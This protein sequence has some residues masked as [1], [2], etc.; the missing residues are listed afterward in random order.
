MD[1]EEYAS[2]SEQSDEDYCPN[3]ENNSDA[4][5]EDGSDAVVDSSDDEET[6]LC[7]NS[8]RCT[9]KTKNGIKKRSNK[10]PTEDTE[11]STENIEADNPAD[12]K[13]KA[14]ALWADFLT[15][16]DTVYSR[17]KTTP[18][19]TPT[20]S[21]RTKIPDKPASIKKQ[22]VTETVEF[23]GEKI[24]VI[25]EIAV[26]STST[27]V[28]SP[29][30]KPPARGVGFGATLTKRPIGGGGGG[31]SSVLGQIGKKSKISTLEK[32]KL[33]WNSF[34]RTEGI[35]EEIQT[36]N[37]GKAG[38]LERQDFLQRTDVRQFQ[39]EKNLRQTKRSNR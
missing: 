16:T 8:K 15:G 1:N 18:A 12:E 33:D 20:T 35:D 26:E 36:H 19:A 39:I 11:K 24:N 38:Y 21:E 34:K 28:Q 5:S 29:A 37:K 30:N 17:P 10:S 3:K 32:T 25:K 6:V 9:S 14:D 27:K 31:L 2:E 23:A 13:Q 4:P 7:T 22:I